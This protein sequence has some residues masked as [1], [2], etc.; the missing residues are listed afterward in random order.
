MHKSKI[1]FTV[2]ILLIARVSHANE[3]DFEPLVNSII[4]R[5]TAGDESAT[6]YSEAR[7]THFIDINGDGEE[8]VIA[9][10]TMEGFG[11]GNNYSF[12]MV[13]LINRHGKFKELD[14]IQ[15]GGKGQRGIDF[16]NVYLKEGQIVLGTQEYGE[17]DPMCCPSIDGSARFSVQGGL[18][19]I[20][21]AP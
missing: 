6:E 1:I 13:A 20:K 10:F 21:G 14:T 12:Y 7:T 3:K 8:D 2:L 11:G 19:E 9:L 17:N 16:S 5:I 4:N 15:V 18:S